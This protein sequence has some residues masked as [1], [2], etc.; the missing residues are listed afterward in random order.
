[1]A[2][3]YSGNGNP[4]NRTFS[5]QTDIQAL[6]SKLVELGNVALVVIDPIT[7]YLGDTD[8]HKNADVRGLLAPL[9]ELASTHN[10]SIIG[11]SH[12]NKTAGSQALMRVTGSL[13][14]V[15]AARA[16]YLVTTD[17][18]EKTRRL[19]LPM[20]NNLGP[21]ATGLAFCIEGVTVSSAAGDLA[22]SRVVWESE[23]VSMTA[24]EA[25]QAE[26]GSRNISA[27][28]TAKAWLQDALENGPIAKI[29]LID[30]AKEEGIANRTLQRASKMLN[31]QKEKKGMADGWWWSLPPK[32][33]KS[34]EDGHVSEVATFRESG[35]LRET[36]SGMAEV[37]L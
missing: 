10:T 30:L 29:E 13:A 16:A 9:S 28:E 21:D 12:L 19:F 32:V 23:P 25:I 34:A 18:R 17:P 20:K 1:V 11:V 24:D 27:V 2:A 33:A 8:S 22:T 26:S 5:L 7:A 37:E 14:F 35:H 4:A 36:E 15:A 31:I 3:G 6:A